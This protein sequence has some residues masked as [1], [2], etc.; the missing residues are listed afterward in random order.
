MLTS[1]RWGFSSVSLAVLGGGGGW[2]EIEVGG[3]G[4][5]FVRAMLA[6]FGLNNAT[7]TSPQKLRAY[8]IFLY[9]I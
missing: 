7:F 5:Q 9:R 2:G 3:G 6:R 1:E 4:L 8:M